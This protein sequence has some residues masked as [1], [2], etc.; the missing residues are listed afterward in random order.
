MDVILATVAEVDISQHKEWIMF[1][2]GAVGAMFLNW[3]AMVGIVWEMRGELKGYKKFHRRMDDT[4]QVVEELD[5][6]VTRVE[7]INGIAFPSRH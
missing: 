7:A 3:F 4:D 1:A 2:L 6:R 5:R